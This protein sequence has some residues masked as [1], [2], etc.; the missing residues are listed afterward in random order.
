MDRN[1]KQILR[2]RLK[3]LK[4][5]S[6]L[7]FHVIEPENLSFKHETKSTKKRNHY[8]NVGRVDRKNEENKRKEFY[9]GMISLTL[10]E[11]LLTRQ[12]K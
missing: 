12:Q 7:G 1:I 11:T 9:L 2:R 8:Q 3:N 4:K 5:C 6:I 10:V